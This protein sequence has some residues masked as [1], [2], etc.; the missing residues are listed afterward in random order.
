MKKNYAAITGDLVQSRSF[1][2]RDKIQ[3]KLVSVLEKVNK[4]FR[5]FVMVKFTIILG[6]EF[7][8]LVSSIEKSY[9]IVKMIQK[10]LYP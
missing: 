3:S 7:Q 10:E 9:D 6:D 2:H 8:G 4:Q 5:D 1:T